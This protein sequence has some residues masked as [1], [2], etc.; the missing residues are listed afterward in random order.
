[1][2]FV[3]LAEGS[4]TWICRIKVKHSFESGLD[5]IP[6]PIY[7]IL[8]PPTQFVMRGQKIISLQLYFMCLRAD[9][10]NH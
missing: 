7:A 9:G 10:G 6:L 5:E 8:H 1:M 2:S 3:L 4:K